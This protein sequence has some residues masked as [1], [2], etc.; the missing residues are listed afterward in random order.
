MYLRRHEGL[1]FFH[2]HLIRNN[3]TPKLLHLI[4]QKREQ[5]RGVGQEP[6]AYGGTQV[7]NT[8]GSFLRQLVKLSFLSEI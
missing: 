4:H 7:R 5:A 1:R 3:P 6:N 8:V 2:P